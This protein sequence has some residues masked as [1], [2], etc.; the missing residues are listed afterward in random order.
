MGE[1]YGEGWFS[2]SLR[3]KYVLYWCVLK[4]SWPPSKRKE[5]NLMR[6]TLFCR[7]M[8]PLQGLV[9]SQWGFVTLIMCTY[10][11][12][13][14]FMLLELWIRTA[15]CG[16]GVSRPLAN[17]TSHQENELFISKGIVNFDDFSC[18]HHSQEHGIYAKLSM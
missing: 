6:L 18:L 16:I 2:L 8:A 5:N 1:F 11:S 10:Q 9:E 17:P 7:F 12:Q 15:E 13:R 14:W 4:Y 3:E